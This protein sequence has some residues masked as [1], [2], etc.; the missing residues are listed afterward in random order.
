[1]TEQLERRW[2]DEMER[3]WSEFRARLADHVAEQEQDEA[4]VVLLPDDDVDGAVGAAPYCQVMPYGGDRLRVEAVSN[5]YLDERH[6]LDEEQEQRLCTAGFARPDEDSLNF[7]LD[8]EQREADRVA[9]VVVEALRWVYGVVHPVYLDA[10][11]LEPRADGDVVQAREEAVGDG[12][13]ELDGDGP[14][15]DRKSVV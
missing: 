7:W 11:G 10:E 5:A 12:L 6:R 1:M 15:T 8:V 4:L 14:W 3:A 13:P 9:H 2:D